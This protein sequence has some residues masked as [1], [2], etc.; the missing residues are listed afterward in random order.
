MSDATDLPQKEPWDIRLEQWEKRSR[1]NKVIGLL[2]LLLVLGVGYWEFDKARSEAAATA[3]DFLQIN[4]L[5]VMFLD[6]T[7]FSGNQDGGELIVTF[8]EETV[9]LKGP[10]IMAYLTKP[11]S[12][13][14]HATLFINGSASALLPNELE[15]KLKGHT[16]VQTLIP[17][18]SED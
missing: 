12:K 10:E 1:R 5:R 16:V 4:R 15:E 13:G 14:K 18:S 3:H 17:K 6:L 11:N 8:T 7:D 2:I 9:I